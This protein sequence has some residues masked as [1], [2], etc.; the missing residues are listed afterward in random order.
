MV[1]TSQENGEE[2]MGL[3]DVGKTLAQ[4][5]GLLKLKKGM[6]PRDNAEHDCWA[7]QVTRNAANYGDRTALIFE[8]KSATWGELNALA[9]QYARYLQSVGVSKGDTVSLLMENRI[10]FMAAFIGIGKVGAV[11]GLINTNLTGKPLVHCISTT[12]S[13]A[14]IIGEEVALAVGDVVSE[15]PLE[16]G[17]GYVYVP[18][19]G[20]ASAPNWATNI[21]DALPQ[22]SDDDLAETNEITLG[23]TAAYIFTSGTTGLPKAAILSNRR[24]LQ[25]ASMAHLAGFKAKET[26]RLYVCLPLYHATGLMLGVGSMI[27][28][29]GSV[30]L[31]RKFSASKFLDETREYNTNLLI[32][33]GELCRYLANTPESQADK[34]TP[35]TTMMGNGLRPDVWMRFKKRF[36]IKRI[37][38][39]YGASEGNVAFANLLNKDMTV[40]MTTAKVALV[41]Y[42]VDADEIKRTTDGWC[43]EVD[44]GNPG[45]LLGH[46]NPEA[47]FEGYTDPAATEKKV[48]R[49]VFEPDD[50]WFN[51]GDLMRTVDVG[52]D[53][54]FQHYQFVDRV[55]DTFRWKSENVSTN[56]VGELINAHPQVEIT[57]VY[58]VEIPGTDG[59]AGM[60]AIVPRP[61]ESIDMASFSAHVNSE[62]PA[63]ARPVFIRL[64]NNLDLT[65]TFKLVKGELR[66]EAYDLDAVTD[67][68][69]VMKPG[70]DA[71][72]PLT[73]EFVAELKAGNAGF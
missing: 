44:K 50:A 1:F 28:A 70:S 38:E 68:I 54:G 48:L 33:V 31:R 66:N 21:N 37:V 53:M 19:S 15:L 32:Y 57:N 25:S 20:Q 34:N 13:K 64:Q 36:G 10:E 52:F 49:G 47:V 60:A 27:A 41:D 2:N 23:D 69:Y 24:A 55:G 56:E 14:C 59:R 42:D 73:A 46:I 39:F 9:N 43:Q 29:G 5:P 58:G 11:A 65:G 62:L 30:F 12:E 51:T 4:V 18:D 7:A 45:L 72:E 61:G 40:G 35:I 17:S 3:V 8:G 6:V 22:L 16:P 71:Y 63:Y 67:P 26:D